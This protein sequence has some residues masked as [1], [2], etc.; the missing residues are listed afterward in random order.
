MALLLA[1]LALRDTRVHVSS[2]DSSYVLVYVEASVDQILSFGTIL[3]VP[4][5]NPN[6]SHVRFRECFDNTGA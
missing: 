4:Y 3:G 5:V 6:D 2:T 1:I